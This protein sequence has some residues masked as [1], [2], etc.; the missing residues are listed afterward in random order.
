[1]SQCQAPCS[2]AQHVFISSLSPHYLYQA[3]LASRG[4]RDWQ[5]TPQHRPTPNTIR[6]TVAWRGWRLVLLS[7][8]YRHQHRSTNS[9]RIGQT[10]GAG[11]RN[12]RPNVNEYTNSHVV[13]FLLSK[14][15]HQST[16]S[17][18][19][20]HNFP[21]N[22]FIPISLCPPCAKAVRSISTP[23]QSK[24]QAAKTAALATTHR[25]TT[26]RC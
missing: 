9:P 24:L 19:G 1:M 12:A 15:Y 26:A 16:G 17:H 10:I 8:K 25:T 5:C 2:K 13:L 4:C 11:N 20:A 21:T 22:L 3:R 23:R 7:S 14:S 18:K 6:S